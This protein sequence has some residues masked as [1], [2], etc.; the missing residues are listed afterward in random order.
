MNISVAESAAELR[1]TANVA[2]GLAIDM[3]Q[4]AN[5]GHPGMPLGMAD[6]AIVL[7]SK[8]LKV[9]PMD[10][11]WFDRDRFVLSGG[12]GSALLYALLH[13]WGFDLSIDDLKAFRQWGSKTPGHPEFGHTPGVETTT[14][15]LGQGLA[16]AVGMALAEK[17][18][19]ARFNRDGFEVVN[20]FTYALAGDGDLQEGISHEASALAGT[21]GLGKLIVCYDSNSISIDGPTAL[22][23]TE[24][25]GRRY[26]A[27]GW[28]VLRADGHDMPLI[29]QALADARAEVLRPSLIICTTTIGFGSPNKA[30]SAEAHGAPLG[31]NEVVLCKQALG[32]PENEHFYVHNT[33]RDFLKGVQPDADTA[34]SNWEHLLLAYEAAYPDL[35][36]LFEAVRENDLGTDWLSVLP[37]FTAD[38]ATR[39]ASGAVLNAIA[40]RI[41][42][43]MGG[44]ADLTPSNNTLAVGIESFS[45]NLPT[46]TY[47]RYGV[48]EH[49][50][51][52]IMNGLALHGGV[53]PYGGTF[54]VFADYMRPAIR[55]AALMGLQVIYVFTHDSIG[56]GEDGPTHQP[57]EHL[58]SL[59]L[60][61]NL[62]V[63]RPADANETAV[64]W[65]VA[66]EHRDGP[67][68]LVLSRQKLKTVPR[69]RGVGA[70]A[71][72]ER[73]AYVL[74]ED[75]DA[76]V[77]LLASG[78]E[79][80]ILLDARA[81][82]KA[83]GIGSR[84]VSV[85]CFELFDAQTD[86]YRDEVLGDLPKVAIEAASTLSWHKYLANDSIII[87]IDDFGASAPAADL[88]SQYGITAENVVLA[89][90]QL[91]GIE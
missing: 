90:H 81:E 42:Q 43:L 53:V 91:L 12:H 24:D 59:R 40:G 14:G 66:L 35:A 75:R 22:S 5:S 51:G 88:Y 87:G 2:R 6:V 57:V 64:A 48:R 19:A 17:S 49:A 32:L 62:R 71:L 33:V 27:Y 46:G 28:Q 15:P 29:E 69:K 39:Q 80:E 67:T 78:S 54:F 45:A 63:I 72:L 85:P 9:N 56:L 82:L 65:K 52:A 4:K 70:A 1:A 73:G 26:E 38:V 23:F 55:L 37:K 30:G 79:L 41:P 61:P 10:T 11:K 25:V 31:E 47:I 18:L 77:T 13:L 3:V 83:Q 84:I 74:M 44:S 58:A 7:W 76:L 68:A 89:T 86:D 20:H 8:F 60:I 16:N 34:Q 36:E 21:W 50:M